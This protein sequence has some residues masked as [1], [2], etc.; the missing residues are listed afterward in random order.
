M[1]SIIP[2]DAPVTTM[3]TAVP[4]IS[5]WVSTVHASTVAT[6]EMDQD[7]ISDY[8][9]EIADYYGV[10]ATDLTVSTNYETSGT[11]SMI[12]PE[13]VAESQLADTII[14]TVAD[15]L[16]IHP[17]N[18]HVTVD[19]KTGEV[20][21]TIIS[22]HFND[23]AG[24]AFDLTNSQYQSEIT[25]L[26]QDIIPDLSIQDVDILGDVKVA[27]EITIDANDAQNDLT[28][29]AWRSEQLLS[30]FDVSV[31]SNILFFVENLD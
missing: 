26:I 20:Q 12:I 29:A 22:D 13:G 30:D 17:K 19:M 16:G 8:A 28:Q 23:A 1:P 5:G 2:S 3:P 31:E 6:S 27:F 7:T 14:G 9:S 11:I 25:N 18:V 10:E 21:F 15:S 24:V 4:T